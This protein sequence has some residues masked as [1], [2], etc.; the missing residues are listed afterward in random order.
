LLI[1]ITAAKEKRILEEIVFRKAH[2]TANTENKWASEK[3]TIM[4][5]PNRLAT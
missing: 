5:V 2:G 4:K 1:N 3:T